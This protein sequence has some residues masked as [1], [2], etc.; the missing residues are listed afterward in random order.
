MSAC[1]GTVIGAVLVQA[2]LKAWENLSF[3]LSF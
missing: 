1:S 2:A 3:A